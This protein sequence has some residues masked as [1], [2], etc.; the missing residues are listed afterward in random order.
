MP[1]NT[2]V[3]KQ[4]VLWQKLE[5]NIND[6]DHNLDGVMGVAILDLTGG[7]KFLFMAMKYFRRPVPSR[8]Q[9]WPSCTVRRKPAS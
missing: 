5:A 1:S 9:S 4:E 7:K 2:A 3:A 8:S 6:I